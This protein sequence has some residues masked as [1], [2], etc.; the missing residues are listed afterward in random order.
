MINFHQN[1][2][3]KKNLDTVK[4]KSNNIAKIKQVLNDQRRRTT[5]TK[6]ETR[7]FR[8]YRFIC[9]ERELI[10][11]GRYSLVIGW[12]DLIMFENIRTII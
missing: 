6:N 1:C 5:T 2:E 11:L 8:F 7:N 12:R 10:Y 3:E 9:L 4:K